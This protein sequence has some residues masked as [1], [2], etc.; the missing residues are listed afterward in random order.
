MKV[1][2][3]DGSEVKYDGSKIILAIEKAMKFGSGIFKPEIAEQIESE[4]FKLFKLL[5]H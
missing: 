2:K 5:K 4:I 1:I 3:R